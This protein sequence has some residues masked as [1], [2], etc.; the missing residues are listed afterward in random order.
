[1]SN[2]EQ[3][4]FYFVDPGMGEKGAGCPYTF[5]KD[6][7]DVRSFITPPSGYE[8]TD[9]KL[10]PYPE[11]KFYDGKIVAQYRKIPLSDKLGSFILKRTLSIV[12]ILGILA[13]LAFFIYNIFW[14]SKPTPQTNLKPKTE[15]KAVDTMDQKQVSDTTA[16]AEVITNEEPVSNEIS[17]EEPVEDQEV[18]KEVLPDEKLVIIKNKK[19]EITPETKAEVDPTQ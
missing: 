5:Y 11:D 13:V 18:Q 9:F 1:M 7:R 12:S 19:E 6:G 17:P 8:L 16:N 14:K 10:E 3:E 2:I 4:H 15:V